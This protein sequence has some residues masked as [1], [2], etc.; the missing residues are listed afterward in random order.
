VSVITDNEIMKTLAASPIAVALL[1]VAIP[2]AAQPGTP[3]APAVA[4]STPEPAAAP[5]PVAAGEA[6]SEPSAVPPE[7]PPSTE[8]PPAAAAT[9]AAIDPALIAAIVDERLA[10]RERVTFKEGFHLQTADGAAKLRIGGY[11]HFDSR[12]FVADDAER[13]VD[14]F[15]FRRIRPELAG[16][17]FDRAGFRLLP[18]FAGGRVVVQDAYV[19][20]TVAAPLELR[21]GKFKE[22]FGLER[23]QSA[24]AIVYVERAFPTSL[25]PNR[26]LGVQVAGNVAGKRVSYQVGIF[27]GVADGGSG[28]G[29]AS[30]DKEVV[31]RVFL[32]PFA[33]QKGSVL[34]QLG[35]G[36]AAS[37][38][39]QRGTVAATDLP[40]L[41]TS[42][43]ASFFAYRAGTTAADTALADGRHWRV[44][45][46]GHFY[47]GPVGVLA[48][49]VHSAQEVALGESRTEVSNDAWQIA[50]NAV[51]LGGA[52]GF[53]GSTARAS[54]DPARKAWGALELAARYHELRVG[55]EAFTFAADPSKSARL[56]RAGTVAANWI[57]ARALRFGLDYEQTRFRGGAADGADRD[58]EHVVLGRVQTV[59]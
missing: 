32:T 45:G 12:F 59:F 20:L 8:T 24:T 48:E 22:P 6:S 16:T 46:Q 52:A 4:P 44:T 49:F 5:S 25:S 33:P 11:T 9:A 35:V 19:E 50:V 42:G 10:A 56:A 23:L 15:T 38:G 55:D 27:N 28:D 53:K 34:E 47:R 26:D 1:L 30:D 29:D 13:N 17:L 14:Q 7:P 36:V 58:T 37:V 3:A 21:F 31:A 18:D 54:F 2:A 57:L 43:Q 41:R 51:V 40:T 39:D